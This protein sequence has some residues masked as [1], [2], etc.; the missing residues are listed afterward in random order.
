VN[1]W[2]LS[3]ASRDRI[4][5]RRASSIIL[6]GPRG[7]GKSTVARLLASELKLP[8]IDLDELLVRRA[9][10]SIAEIFSCYGQPWFRRLESEIL[11]DVL[12]QARCRPMV[13]STGGG[14]VVRQLNR[15]RLR[16]SR[17]IRVF[18]NGDAQE[19][20]RRIKADSATQANRPALTSLNLAD[21]IRSLLEQRLPWY[22]QVATVELD[23]STLSPHN[24]VTEVKN[25]LSKVNR[26]P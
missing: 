25:Y 20:A 19:L 18:L 10:M 12:S 11:R 14:V 21:E 16:K 22:R 13:I 6:L 8:L 17:A 2:C 26:R 24:V 4:V 1:R 9:G 7:S 5:K 15:Q 3:I 23:A